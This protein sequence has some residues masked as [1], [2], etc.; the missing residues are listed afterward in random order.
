MSLFFYFIGAIV[1]LP[2]HLNASLGSERYP[3]LQL[4]V[5]LPNTLEQICWHSFRARLLHSFM[6]ETNRQKIYNTDVKLC[7][8]YVQVHCVRGLFLS[9][10]F[11]F[12]PKTKLDNKYEPN[13]HGCYLKKM[14]FSDRV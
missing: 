3:E 12:S 10:Y 7:N 11:Y 5:K 2:I 6:S 13:L 8:L 9:K 1:H 14:L 4:Q